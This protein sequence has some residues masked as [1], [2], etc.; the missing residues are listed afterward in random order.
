MEEQ[1]EDIKFLLEQI[2]LNIEKEDLRAER[3]MSQDIMEDDEKGGFDSRG[4]GTENA[5]H[6]VQRYQHPEHCELFC[7]DLAARKLDHNERE[8]RWH[9]RD[10]NTLR[11]SCLR[12]AFCRN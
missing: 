4:S 12:R 6:G 10:E 2:K 5:H 3:D 1:K 8:K 11:E 7:F 9:E